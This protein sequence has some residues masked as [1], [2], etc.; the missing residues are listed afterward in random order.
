MNDGSN[1][2]KGE[3]TEDASFL[4]N[5]EEVLSK[6][7]SQPGA[8]ES[9]PSSVEG[10]TPSSITQ[11]EEMYRTLVENLKDI[12]FSA[13]SN[14]VITY[15]SPRVSRYGFTPDN[16]IGQ[17]FL[18]I[19]EP[20]DKKLAA[21]AYTN[22]MKTGDEKSVE[23]RIRDANGYVRWF[24]VRGSIRRDNGGNVSGFDG[25]LRDINERKQS[26]KQLKEQHNAVKVHAYE[27]EAAN[28]ELEQTQEKLVEVNT[29][30]QESRERFMQIGD[31]SPFPI[32]VLTPDGCTDYINPQFEKIFGYTADEIPTMGSWLKLVFPDDE[33]RQQAIRNWKEDKIKFSQREAVKREFDVIRKDGV[34]R[35]ATVRTIQ[36]ENGRTYMVFH[37][38]TDSKR[39]DEEEK[40]L[41]AQLMEINAV[42]EEEISERREAERQ[43]QLAQEEFRT[44]FE[45]S[46][47]GITVTDKH[48]NI[49]S[50]NR[51][52][53]LMLGMS[54]DEL[55]M[56]PVKS[57]YPEDEWKRIR[58]SNVRQ[59][60]MQ[61][62]L[63]TKIYRKNPEGIIDVVLS[64][65]VLR[66][67]DDQIT[68]SI[69]VIADVT[70]RKQAEAEMWR[71][72]QE[73]E[74]TNQQLKTAIQHAK[75][76]A[77]KAEQASK[78]KSEF[79]ASMSHEIRTPMNAILG[80]ADLLSET[81]L[82]AEQQQ[83]V[84][85][86]QSAGENLLSIIND[87]LDISKVES[88]HLEL[89]EI[90]FDLVELVEKTCEIM[91]VRAHEKMIELGHYI[92]P[93]VPLKLKGDPT[94]LRQIFI[95]LIGNAIKFTDDGGIFI[96]I[97]R[98]TT[99]S[100]GQDIGV[101]E[102]ICSVKDTGT[103]IPPDN[104]DT[105]FEVFTQV[106]ASTTRKHGGTGLG[107]TISRQLSELMGGRIWA[108][109]KMGEG[110][111]FY[112][113]AKFRTSTEMEVDQ[114]RTCTA[115]I[116]MKGLKVLIVDDTDTN[117][118][119][120]NKTLSELGALVSEAEN[121]HE[122][123][124]ELKRAKE[125]SNPYELVLLDCR[126]PGMDGFEM[127]ERVRSELGVNGT[128]IMMLTS[129]TRGGDISRSRELGVAS[130][131]V[132]PVKKNDLL[133]AIANALG[134]SKTSEKPKQG[135]SPVEEEV[136]TALQI[137]L[138]EDNVDNRLLVQSFL[139]K[140]PYQIDIAENGEIAVEQFKSNKYDLV[141]MDVQ[142]PVMDG[143]TATR[144]IRKWEREQEL[145]ETPIVALTAHATVE[146]E[147][148]SINAG[149]TGHLTKPIKKAKLLEA[150]RELTSKQ[151]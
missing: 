107:L 75:E 146:D 86:F 112:F 148:K 72:K 48:E 7:P 37:D 53:E 131:L 114:P 110:S 30:L 38:I 67:S 144:E 46:A 15:A 4:G 3:R 130:Y 25:V 98:M 64:L 26:E 74:E 151:P 42:L 93:D 27:L 12:I 123:L 113:T 84:N 28:E 136:L 35:N 45:N 16:F 111:T 59:K 5:V 6:G 18:E 90:G 69:G 125:L 1:L 11:S 31:L 99:M 34:V 61:H 33:A 54:G 121:G 73:T 135:D 138:V 103:G 49:I 118:L 66:D 14:G 50:W 44:V 76:M 129:D 60:G 108:E 17:N 85:T 22:T 95:N 145:V 24:E 9:A 109:S 133:S 55:Y 119:I 19:V 39:A 120:L 47:V 94:R 91:A 141:M 127:M 116:N 10:S 2:K 87:I 20:D 41:N 80:M 124:S 43:L 32:W 13:D 21:E 150:I 78:A 81:N 70:E 100:E 115:P 36:M 57:L 58:S 77:I 79:L 63:E 128:T 132:K 102:L 143:Y 8:V 134:Q 88:G 82:G 101:I 96:E 89:E 106:D 52:A 105:I 147:N 139:K 92:A 97:K 142:M 126:M 122:G 29:E 51:F 68:G 140:T 104:V 117:R 65:S 62:Q 40:R 71:A 149:C 137:L 83:Y 23:L 56:K